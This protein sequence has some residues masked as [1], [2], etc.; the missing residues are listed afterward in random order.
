MRP[1]LQALLRDGYTVERCQPVDARYRPGRGCTLRYRLE[2]HGPARGERLQCL[3]GARLFG[4]ATAADGYLRERLAPLAR[5]A[6]GHPALVPFARPVA[7][8]SP[9]ALAL[10]AFP[11]DADLPALHQLTDLGGMLP[12]LAGTPRDDLAG[13]GRMTAESCQIEVVRYARP[14]RCLLRYALEGTDGAGR[15]VQRALYGHVDAGGQGE[16]A[17]TVTGI[18]RELALHGVGYRFAVPR[19]TGYLADLGLALSEAIPGKPAIPSLLRAQAR[20]EAAG[21]ALRRTLSACGRIAATLHT[22][23][24]PLGERRTL[25]GDLAAVRRHLDLVAGRCP[26]LAAQLGAFLDQAETLDATTHDAALPPGFCHGDFSP[27]AVVSEG[28]IS[29]LTGLEA[30]C[31]AEPALDL[32][33]FLAHLRLLTHEATRAASETPAEGRTPD[34]KGEEPAA[35]ERWFLRAYADQAGL[36]DLDRLRRRAA[37]FELSSLARLAVER[38]CQLDA[39]GLRNVLA[40]LEAMPETERA[41]TS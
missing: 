37:P 3:V 36:T 31:Q 6:A 8:V 9:L 4:S 2:L 7:A 21:H 25:A 35:A 10:H 41:R 1:H 5:R 30:A 20:G 38:W 14:G 39:R 19:C 15:R 27:T 34:H 11:I 13:L 32:G 16:W 26:P 18:V 22:S 12:L 29:G 23:G 17:A 40:A 33:R 24:I 28:L